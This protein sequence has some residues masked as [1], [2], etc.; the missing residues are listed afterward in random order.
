MTPDDL[1]LYL[2]A[3]FILLETEGKVPTEQNWTAKQFNPKPSA[4]MLKADT[5]GVKLTDELLVIDDDPRNYKN[6]ENSL[7]KLQQHI[8]Y[9]LFVES[10]F[11]V[12]TGSGGHHFYFR[13]PKSL[14]V[15]ENLPMYPGIEFKSVGRQVIGA[16]SIHPDTGKKYSITFSSLTPK[17][18]DMAPQK[19]M[20]LIAKKTKQE[21]RTGLTAYSDNDFDIRRCKEHI[22]AMPAAVEGD[23]GDFQTYK[24]CAIGHDFGLSPEVFLPILRQWNERCQPPW[25][26]D[27][28][29]TKLYNAYRYSQNGLGHRSLEIDFPAIS[30]KYEIQDPEKTPEQEKKDLVELE[31]SLDRFKG[32]NLPKP[33][34]FNASLYL[35]LHPEL[36]PIFC[37]NDFTY[38]VVARKSM[39][40]HPVV[41]SEGVP[42]TD[43]D[44]L[45]LR[46]WFAT[47]FRIDFPAAIMHDA[48]RQAALLNKFHPVREFLLSLAWDQTPRLSRW[49][50]CYLGAQD[51]PYV[52]A[53]GKK[54]MVAAISRIFEPGCKWD[55]MLHLEGEQGIGK[56]S[57]C[58][59]LFDPWFT[60]ASIDI[61]EKDGVLVMQGCWGVEFGETASFRKAETEA[62]KSFLTRTTD[63]IR[64]PFDRLPRLY[65]RQQVFVSTTNH[66]TYTD[67]TGNR[68]WWPV[69]VKGLQGDKLLADRNQLWAEAYHWYLQKEKLFLDT[70]QLVRMAEDEQRLRFDEDAWTEQVMEYL[71]K[72]EGTV[73]LGKVWEECLGRSIA[74]FTRSDQMRLAKIMKLLKWERKSERNKETGEIHRVYERTKTEF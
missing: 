1:N 56:S 70:P 30:Q 59:M 18:I 65:P 73:L 9:S 42:V 45:Q 32:S 46:S 39:P 25:D 17:H 48:I 21:I 60:D 16:G 62:Q 74:L 54:F 20:L 19:L 37:Y 35:R 41:V 51:S 63:K 43:D 34:L 5:F 53:V 52:Q 6:G 26:E 69:K 57:T 10:K 55:Y 71:S 11:V 72:A 38:T 4:K 61:N 23:G 44:A 33:I 12:Q 22:E 47:K 7:D 40:W 50:P 14:N 29:Q 64:A 13:K 3:G 27:D 24:V 68:R 28:L 66:A 36:A 8:G 2:D 31:G 67:E 49:L 58:K 15:Q